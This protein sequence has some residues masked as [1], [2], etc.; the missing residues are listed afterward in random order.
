MAPYHED[1][2]VDYIEQKK[3][4]AT[5]RNNTR[6]MLDPFPTIRLASTDKGWSPLLKLQVDMYHTIARF[7]FLL[8]RRLRI[9]GTRI[10]LFASSLFPNE[11]QAVSSVCPHFTPRSLHEFC[12]LGLFSRWWKVIFQTWFPFRIKLLNPC[13]Q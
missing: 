11:N 6:S 1:F 8:G 3:W 10:Y 9:V 13:R 12:R 4:N 7:M 2:L 5:L